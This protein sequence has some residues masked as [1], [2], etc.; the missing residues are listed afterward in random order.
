MPDCYGGG[1]AGTDALHH[2][3]SKHRLCNMGLDAIKRPTLVV[4]MHAPRFITC[5]GKLCLD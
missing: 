4:L 2:H 5:I 3:D 1:S